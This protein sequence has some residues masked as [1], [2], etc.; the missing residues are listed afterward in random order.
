M[1]IK[2]K[3]KEAGILIGVFIVAVL[4]FS[5]FTNK[6]ND[7]MTA[8]IGTATF[9]KIGFDCGGY[10]I[11]AVPGYAQP[12]DIPT[13]RDT[14]TPVLSGK[15]NV[16]INAYENA[17]S[18]MEYKVYSLDGTEALLE[19]KIK[20]PGKTEM[21]DLNKSGLLDEERVLEIILNYNKEK[22][23]HFYTRIADAEK[24]DIQQCLD[25]VTTFHNGALNKEEGVG[26][27]KAIEPNEDGDNST[28]AHV[29]IHSNYDQVSYG[30]LEP[31]L[32]GG[33]HWEIK[34]MNDTSSS[35]QAEFIVRCK[36]E[37]NEDDLYKVREFFRVRYDSYAKRG[38]LLDYDRTMEQIFD[39][40]KKVLSEKGVLL[41][42]SE[43]DV[44]YLNDKDGSIVSFVQ[45]DDLWS[46]SK[47]T[48]EVSLVFSFAASE[49]TDERNLT[50]QNEIQLLEADGNGNVTFAVYGY[51]NRGEHEGQVGVAVYYYNVEQ[52]SVE[53][54]VFIP[55]DTSWGNAIHELGKL[56]YYSVDREM[57]YVLAGDTFYETNV[58]KEKT[59]ELVTGLTEDHYVASSDGRLLAYQSKSGENGANELTIMN[60]SSGKTRT[61]TGKEGEN[62][63][64]L[65][66]VKNDFVY[67]TSRIEDAGQTAAG[68]DASPMHKVE[69]QNSKGKTVKTY[70]QKEI[71]ILGAKMEKNRVILERAV[72]DG[73]IYTATAEEYISNN[74]EQKESNIYLDSYV[75][76]LKK[77]QMRLTYE[78]GISDK[79]PKVLK[80]K[81]VMF[82]N[83][84]TITF[85]YDK[86]EKQYYVY[87]YGKLQ[88]S[89][90]IAGDAIQ[91]ADSYGGVVVDQS[92]SYIWERG[93]RDLNYTIDHSED[94][95]AQIKAKLDS[96]VS[97]MEALKEYN[98]GASLNLTGCTAEQLAYIINRGKPVIGMKEAGKPIIL[99]GYTDENVIYVDAAS[100]ERKISTFEEMDA[101]TAGTGHTYIG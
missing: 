25:Y 82:E 84:T 77:K 47:E 64:P 7:N 92:Q 56:V 61:V 58:E 99:V 41:G 68:E 44:P 72:R 51:M 14:I 75:T 76:E 59:K 15:L 87:G 8:D 34:E 46:Y 22:T 13:I 101:L 86:K 17:I 94:M 81:Q 52:S 29:T 10:G 70:E 97:P 80:P 90:E 45:A 83:P 78:D 21:L 1:N 89:Y 38:Y 60:L 71:Y 36:G 5:Y 28:F 62:I 69:I 31:K 32:E 66:F 24:A 98:S 88:G 85:D 50:N 96:G 3:L 2:N 48:D 42:I 65:G 33:E 12:M 11:N 37:E 95:A 55:T 57:L 93:N 49:N 53:E 30:E 16:E 54:K 91:K 27:G 20:K 35:I 63:Y 19:K 18:S 73:S 39:P 100:G 4:V 26:V 9:P 40:T 6:G 74:E 43:Y 67:G 79:E 23:V